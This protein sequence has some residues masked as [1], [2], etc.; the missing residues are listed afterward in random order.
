[1]CTYRGNSRCVCWNARTTGTCGVLS[2]IL[3]CAYV[4]CLFICHAHRHE[5]ARAYAHFPA[6]KMSSFNCQRDCKG[7]GYGVID[8]CEIWDHDR[9]RTCDRE[10]SLLPCTCATAT[11]SHISIRIKWAVWFLS[12]F[13]AFHWANRQMFL[14]KL[15]PTKRPNCWA[16]SFVIW[17]SGRRLAFWWRTA[18]TYADMFIFV[19]IDLSLCLN[20]LMASMG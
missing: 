18:T 8:V 17:Q 7:Y 6:H 12:R 14:S 19:C 2:T 1:M 3:I 15:H 4:H 5:R 13:V 20:K 9:F 11:G 10:Q 16:V